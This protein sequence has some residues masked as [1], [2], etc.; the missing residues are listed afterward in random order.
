MPSN[1]T[2][3]DVYAGEVSAPDEGEEVTANTSGIGKGPVRPAYQALY[4]KIKS[5]ILGTVTFKSVKVDATGETATAAVPGSVVAS[6]VVIAGTGMSAITGDVS[7]LAGRVTAAVSHRTSAASG[8]ADLTQKG[9]AWTGV[10]NNDDAGPNPTGI[11]ALTND[12]RALLA[13][14]AWCSVSLSAGVA[15]FLDRANCFAVSRGGQEITVAFSGA[16]RDA[17][18]SLQLSVFDVTGA[19]VH[20]KVTT[21]SATQIVID[22]TG[23]GKDAAVDALR[24]DITVMGRQ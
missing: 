10:V 18:Y 2:P 5:M 15:S 21:R 20:P 8:V 19:Q 11:L 17:F 22:F 16:M 4:N 24:I 6:A 13:P 7:S 1:L 23:S 12:F 14:K 9:V 3:L